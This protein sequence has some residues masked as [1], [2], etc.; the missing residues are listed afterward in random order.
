MAD[1]FAD[2]VAVIVGASSGI[3]RAVA[4]ALAHAGARVIAVGRSADALAALQ[5]ALAAEGRAIETASADVRDADGITSV[6]RRAA[7]D[8]GRL[9]LLY[10]GAGSGLLGFYE[11]TPLHQWEQVFATS[12]RGLVYSIHAAYPIMR[13]QGFGHICNVASLAGL[14][15]L[16]AS[17]VYVAAKHAVVGLSRALRLEARRAGVHVSVVCPAAVDTAIFDRAAYINFDVDKVLAAR[18]PG[19]QSADSCARQILRGI[20]RNRATIVPGPAR[21][22]WW[23]YRLVPGLWERMARRVSRSLEAAHLGPDRAPLP[24]PTARDVPPRE[25][26][27]RE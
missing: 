15:P 27:S 7:T 24:E 25:T 6:I 3:G 26:A 16:P 1:Y 12:V 19:I 2:K 11:E 18:P 4:H 8:H 17:T 23:L 21:P 22:M 20:R 5:A 10:N 14:I 13:A 9:D